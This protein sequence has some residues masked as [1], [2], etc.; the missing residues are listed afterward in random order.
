MEDKIFEAVKKLLPDTTEAKEVVAAV[1]EMLEQAKVQLETEYNEKLE[2]AYAELSNEL[3]KYE[4][5]KNFILNLI[6]RLI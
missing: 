5:I 3:A 2:E 1:K 6:V 4:R